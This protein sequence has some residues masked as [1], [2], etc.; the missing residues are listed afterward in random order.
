MTTAT[1]LP[2]LHIAAPGI[3]LARAMPRSRETVASFLRRTGWST[4][5]TPTICVVDGEP[6]LRAQWRKT[7]IKAGM[8]VLFQSLPRGGSMNGGSIAGL[9]GMIALTALAPW[10]GAAIVGPGGLALAGT[11]LAI[12]KAVISGAIL[13]GG[14][15]LLSTL[16]AVKAGGDQEAETPIYSWARQS[17]SAKPLQPIPC[18]YGR[19]KRTCDYAA[20]PWSSFEGNNQYVHLL[21]SE[22]VGKFEREQIL[23]GDTVLWSAEDGLNPNFTGV[24]IN[25]YDPDEEITAFPVN[26][27]T[28]EEVDGQELQYPAWTGGFIAN[29]SGTTATRLVCDIVCPGVGE[30][31]DDGD[32]AFYPIGARAEYRPVDNSGNPTGDGTWSLLGSEF[33]KFFKSKSDIRFSVAGD[34]AP[35][36]Y[37]VR[38]RRLIFK[39]PDPNVSDTMTWAGLR[40]FI[41]GPKAFPVSTIA[42]RAKATDQFSGDSASNLAVVETRILPVWTGTAWEDQPTRSP[43]WAA[44]DIATNTEYGGRFSDTRM[45]FQA[46]YD[47]DTLC[48]SRGDTFDYDF[49]STQPVPDALDIAL[50]ACRAKHKWLG[51]TL[52]LFRDEWA[53]VPEVMLTDGEIVRGSLEV[54]YIMKP[55]DA[56]QCVVHEYINEDTWQIEEAIAPRDAT[57]E[58]IADATRL[59]VQGVV[60]RA[61]AQREA[62]FLLRENLYRRRHATFETEYEGRMLS[63]GTPILLQS[64]MPLEWGQGA[65]IAQQI[66]T[67]LYLDRALTWQAGQN[68]VVLRTPRAKSFGPIKCSMGANASV[69][70]LDGTDLGIVEAA[71]G[72]TLDDV[73]DLE[74][75][76]PL[77]SLAFGLGTSWIRRGVV[78]RGTPSGS[79]VQISVYL[80]DERVHVEDGTPPPPLPTGTSLVLPTFPQVFGLTARILANEVPRRVEAQWAPS[81]GAVTYVARVSYDDGENWT[82]L[83]ETRENM[84]SAVVDPL[85][86]TLQVAAVNASGKQGP[87][88]AYE[89]GAPTANEVRADNLQATIDSFKAGLRE[90]VVEQNDAALATLT[91]KQELQAQIQAELDAQSFLDRQEW[92]FQLR[93][94]SD[95]VTASYTEAITVAVG[96]GSAI[97]QSIT[98]LQAQVDNIGANL[99][100]SWTTAVTP[101]GALA[102]YDIVAKVDDGLS[103]T[104]AAMTIAAYSLVGGGAYSVIEL[105]AEKVVVKNTVSGTTVTPFV[106]DG[107]SVAI[108]GTIIKD[109]TVTA[110][111]MDVA[112]LSAVAVSMGTLRGGSIELGPEGEDPLIV[113][114]G[115]TP[116]APFLDFYSA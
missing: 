93:A 62:E 72:L 104:Q 21:L 39:N 30:V 6:V 47:L 113:L 22:G 48:A 78:S 90:K 101:A 19:T 77:P 33:S 115:A 96:P 49:T 87:W 32:F 61:Q 97:V 4:T 59:Q 11:G 112:E 9:L 114:S 14:G 69:V 16:T 54:E 45:D 28:S 42:I 31:N 36:R 50:G 91:E 95:R 13:L 58:M 73:L 80:D 20:V 116:S 89:I 57:E 105:D 103:T 82:A 1:M 15:F 29:A 12:G 3:E 37:E 35:G 71:Q 109:G 51:G 26:V 27:E 38:L 23:I 84:L 100:V 67:S 106:I 7:R 2:V 75:G 83:G 111:K 94:T 5:R 43:A 53:S 102:A 18:A 34:V 99:N 88:A 44:Y 8:S 107:T 41:T 60:N 25:F 65:K 81:A 40:A 64:D 46:F 55:S 66:G 63:I 24:T 70:V 98:D 79:R 10:A 76:S 85:A 86:L 68:Y 52:S 108:S 56:Q 110:E 74:P 17:N 92:R